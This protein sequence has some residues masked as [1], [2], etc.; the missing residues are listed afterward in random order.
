MLNR[1]KQLLISILSEEA[2]TR[3]SRNWQLTLLPADD[4]SRPIIYLML[5]WLPGPIAPVS[6]PTPPSTLSTSVALIDMHILISRT[7]C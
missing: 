1:A 7:I 6:P 3:N 5:D 4:V 2:H